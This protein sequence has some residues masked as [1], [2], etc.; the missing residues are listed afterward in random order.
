[1]STFKYAEFALGCIQNRNKVYR[2]D[3]FTLNAERRECYRSM[4]VFDE[5][6]RD[7]VDRT[8]SV[9]GFGGAHIATELVIDFDGKDLEKVRQ[10]VVRFCKYLKTD[11]DVPLEYLRI[12]FS[13]AKGF[14]LGVPIEAITDNPEARVDFYVVF[15][16]MVKELTEG[17]ECVDKTIYEPRRLIR[18]LNTINGKSGLYKI[19]LSFQELESLDVESILEL[20]KHPRTVDYE[21]TSSVKVIPA[22]N[23]MFVKWPDMTENEQKN[24]G[25]K[26]VGLTHSFADCL[27][28]VEAGERNTA[29]MKIVGL[30]ISQGMSE[31]ITMEFLRMWNER[32]RPPMDDAELMDLVR[33]GYER[34]GKEQKFEVF[35]FRS[36][37]EAYK[38]YITATSENKVTTGFKNIDDMIRGLSPGETLCILGKTSVGKSALLQHIGMNYARISKQPTL[39][40]SLEMPMSSVIERALQIELGI[41]GH[42]IE[43]EIGNRSDS[44]ATRAELLFTGV[45]NFFTITRSGLN[46]EMVKRGIHFA[47][48][49]VYH[50]KTKLL[51]LDYITLVRETGRDLYETVS[52]TARGLKELAKIEDVPVIFI[53][54]V[55]RNFS[56][57]KELQIDAARD[58]GVIDEASDFILGLWRDEAFKD[59]ADEDEQRHLI[60]AVVKNRKGGVG[61]TKIAME[62]KTLRF[63]DQGS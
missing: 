23:E 13:G 29:G 32:N 45:P 11:L 18:I 28:G 55:N 42:E 1:M 7:W 39:F 22:L 59:P 38:N 9:Q 30:F 8:G 2:L 6:L 40:F 17:I 25:Q 35:D 21:P 3:E 46:L 54:Q 63:H 33:R 16:E 50:A 31:S 4:F 5:G 56:E 49:Y 36:G 53:S 52:K 62:K 48:E 51:L 20:A 12:A 61:K 43:S 10:E 26:D 60:L 15:R 41:S 58:S 24:V 57:Y 37:F 47:E 14:H 19:P 27:E 34:Y 44:I